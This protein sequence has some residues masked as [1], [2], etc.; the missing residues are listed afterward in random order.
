MNGL[1]PAV[2]DSRKS[3]PQRF[4]GRVVLRCDRCNQPATALH[5]VEFAITDQFWCRHCLA[6]LPLLRS[7]PEVS[8]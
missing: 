6:A 5:E 2:F 1:D 8:D 3:E 7:L 4:S